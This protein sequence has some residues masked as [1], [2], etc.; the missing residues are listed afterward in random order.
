MPKPLLAVLQ[1]R[2]YTLLPSLAD[3]PVASPISLVTVR[4]LHE[5]VFRGSA[6]HRPGERR[7][8]NVYIAGA[9]HRPPAWPK[10]V[11][12]MTQWGA[13]TPPARVRPKRGNDTA[14]GPAGS[15]QRTP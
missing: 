13:S 7:R 6:R 10:V 8:S 2:L 11:S 5:T 3:L 12:R 15:H 9:R 1:D 4:E 14:G